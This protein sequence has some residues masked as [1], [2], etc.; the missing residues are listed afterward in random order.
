[1]KREIIKSKTALVPAVS[2]LLML[3]F[4]ASKLSCS[5]FSRTSL[6]E[7]ICFAVSE[8]TLALRKSCSFFSAFLSPLFS[9][10]FLCQLD[11][12]VHLLEK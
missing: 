8:S 9:N 1:M 2:I 10:C 12:V 4:K 5:F 11:M 3:S 7:S 6:S